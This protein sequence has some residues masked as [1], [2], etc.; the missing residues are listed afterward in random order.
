[1]PK[2]AEKYLLCPAMKWKLRHLEAS[3]SQKTVHMPSVINQAGILFFSIAGGIIW[4]S[5]LMDLVLEM[6]RRLEE[7]PLVLESWSFRSEGP[8][9]RDPLRSQAAVQLLTLLG[10]TKQQMVELIWLASVGGVEPS[11]MW[12]AA[13][14]AW[15]WRLRWWRATAYLHQWLGGAL[16][17]FRT[18]VGAAGWRLGVRLWGDKNKNRKTFKQLLL[19]FD[20]SWW[21]PVAVMS[22]PGLTLWRRC[23]HVVERQIWLL[24]FFTLC[25]SALGKE[26]GVASAGSLMKVQPVWWRGTSGGA[27]KTSSWFSLA[28]ANTPAVTLLI[29]PLWLLKQERHVHRVL[30]CLQRLWR[31]AWENEGSWS[32]ST[33]VTSDR[34]VTSPS[35]KTLL[36]GC[37]RSRAVW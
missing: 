20:A 35:V 27:I 3:Q 6:E 1:M 33:D 32:F 16:A 12:G 13:V 9:C 34:P 4:T 36:E 29:A 10:R 15:C 26:L 21:T 31:P 11:W 7:E 2:V 19:H 24:L 8:E 18:T 22:P 14:W 25:R 23:D 17:S 28:S 5:W 37:H 30:Q